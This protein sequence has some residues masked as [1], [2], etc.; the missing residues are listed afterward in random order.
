M[1]RI[2]RAIK[3][4]RE[5]AEALEGVP[6]R[7]PPLFGIPLVD[8]DKLREEADWLEQWNQSFKEVNEEMA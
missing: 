2:E 4:L 1:T 3:A 7:T 5:C 6:R 8:Q